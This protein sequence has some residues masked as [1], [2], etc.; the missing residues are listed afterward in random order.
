MIDTLFTK[1]TFCF[2]FSFF[3][4]RIFAFEGLTDPDSPIKSPAHR[5]SHNSY[6]CSSPYDYFDSRPINPIASVLQSAE[7][8]KRRRK[9]SSLTETD[10]EMN[11]LNQAIST[12][13]STHN[14]YHNSCVDS[15]SL[16]SSQLRKFS[17]SLSP[18][19]I[20]PSSSAVT[21]T[22]TQQLQYNHNNNQQ[23][24]SYDSPTHQQLQRL[25]SASYFIS[26][27]RLHNGQPI[28]T[29]QQSNT[30]SSSFNSPTNS[31][32]SSYHVQATH[33]SLIND[34][35]NSASLSTNRTAPIQIVTNYPDT[36]SPSST[37][38][39]VI[40]RG[41]C[42]T[43]TNSVSSAQTSPIN[44]V[45]TVQSVPN[46]GVHITSTTHHQ[47]RQPLQLL[48][49]NIITVKENNTIQKQYKVDSS[50]MEQITPMI[51]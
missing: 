19:Y 38:N 27:P 26:P 48:N 21:F 32:S 13:T 47:V 14:S 33:L 18:A 16:R 4:D 36:I 1:L 46:T 28:T 2:C 40:N 35:N 6:H 17:P 41:F 20:T 11:A 37:N 22:P 12:A 45:T 43:P 42:I 3:L 8:G 39:K 23:Y 31:N 30:L 44:H 51:S 25:G 15:S 50:A 5:S 9:N 10:T 24:N 7:L 34:N 49:N 29:Q